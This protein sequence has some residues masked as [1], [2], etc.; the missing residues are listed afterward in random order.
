LSIC[1]VVMQ[2]ALVSKTAS[3]LFAETQ[4]NTA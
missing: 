2:F 1:L 3:V 4:A